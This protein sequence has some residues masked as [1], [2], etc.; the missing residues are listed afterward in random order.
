MNATH[1]YAIHYRLREQPRRLIHESQEAPNEFL[2]LL[3]VLL[4]LAQETGEDPTG[5]TDGSWEPNLIPSLKSSA[6]RA[7]VSRVRIVPID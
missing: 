4:H 2:A 3:Q 7:G 5:L 1:R 6:D